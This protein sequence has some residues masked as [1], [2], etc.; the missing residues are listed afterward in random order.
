MC[1]CAHIWIAYSGMLLRE[2]IIIGVAH[3]ATSDVIGAHIQPY[4]LI[5]LDCGMPLA[6]YEVLTYFISGW[7][8]YGDMCGGFVGLGWPSISTRIIMDATPSLSSS[9]ITIRGDPGALSPHYHHSHRT[10]GII[11][12]LLSCQRG[13]FW[14]GSIFL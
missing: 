12:Q 7:C 8:V 2:L 5:Y 4:T 3:L 14:F 6:L 11:T 9:T 13:G 1:L 10:W